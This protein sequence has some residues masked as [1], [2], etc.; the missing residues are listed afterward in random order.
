MR[1]A[2]VLASGLLLSSC[3]ISFDGY[4]LGSDDAGAG[5]GG[6]AGSGASGGSGGS[7]AAG[8]AGGTAT[9]GSAGTGATAGGGG[10]GATGA[11][12]GAAGS[13]AAGATGGTAGGGATGG[14]AGA[15]ATGGTGGSAP[16]PTNLS[17]PTMVHVPA[18]A[19]GYC[20]DGTEVT[21]K[22]YQ[23]FLA[24]KPDTAKQIAACSWNSAFAP[25]ASGACSP[26]PY[27]PAGSPDSPI[28]CVNWCD[29]VAYCAWAGKR[30]CGYI[31]GG[32]NNPDHSGDAAASQWYAACSE[33]A[34][35]AFPYGTT[36]QGSYCNGLD[37]PTSVTTIPVGTDA[38]CVGGYDGIYDLSGNVAEWEDSCT[39]SGQSAQCLY[40][41]GGYLDHDSGNS[42]LR[43][44]SAPFGQVSATAPSRGFRC[45]YGP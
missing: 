36:Y 23:T 44:D 2:A 12:G 21:N 41:G 34:Q 43:C 27:D 30:L 32:T 4:V 9:G 8:G 40:R 25:K 3:A 18:G 45:C 31:G 39:G 19:K 22:Q 7:G 17:G 26:S 14:A 35:R 28:S 6:T 37:F 11:T 15:G 24:S 16:C 13:G 5:A 1:V 20:I 42:N 10:T 29:A 33:Q 38:K